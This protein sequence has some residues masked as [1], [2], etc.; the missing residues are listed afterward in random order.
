MAHR[1]TC[2]QQRNLPVDDQIALLK[3]AFELSQLR[4][5]SLFHVEMGTRE[6]G[7]SPTAWFLSLKIM[8]MF[9]E[10]CSHMTQHTGSGCAPRTHR[11]TAPHAGTVQ[12]HRVLLAQYGS[13]GK[14]A[15]E[16]A[17]LTHSRIP[18][19]RT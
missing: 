14:P 5:N 6:C 2:T 9:A 15:R 11:L 12:H 7:Q 16:Q 19:P 10:L 4:F 17:A 18:A 1:D 8:A 13:T 3:E